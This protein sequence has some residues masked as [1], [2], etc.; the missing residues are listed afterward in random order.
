MTHISKTLFVAPFLFALTCTSVLMASDTDKDAE[1]ELWAKE[2]AA[3]EKLKMQPNVKTS[4]EGSITLTG[5]PESS[6]NGI[7]GTFT[8]DG[9][10]MLLRLESPKLIDDLKKVNGKTA[11]LTGKIRVSGKYFV[12]QSVLVPVPGQPRKTRGKRGGA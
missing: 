4:W 11:T 5:T 10:P 8:V 7:V 3:D 2:E 1:A 12:A 9:K 6:E